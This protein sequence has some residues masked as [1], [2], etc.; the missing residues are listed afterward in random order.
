MRVLRA[1][2]TASMFLLVLVPPA[3][4]A[5]GPLE[6]T[7]P[8]PSVV[9]DP[10]ATAKFTITVATDT[11][12]RVDLTVVQ[13]PEG[14]DTSLRGGGSTVSA[15]TTAPDPETP[16]TISAELSA[17][18]AVPEDAAP[19]ANQVIIEGRSAAGTTIR[20]TLDISIEP[21]E[22][23]S[24]TM[25]SDFPSQSGSAD[26]TFN[27]PLELRNSTNQ[28]LTLSFEA[29]GPDGWRVDASPGGDANATTAVVDA[30]GLSSVE[31]SVDPP[32][33][34]AAGDYPI[35][36]R[37]LGGPEPVEIELGVTITGNYAMSMGTEDQRLS[38]NVTVGSSTTLNI[39]V[40]NDGSAPLENV[41]LSAT[42]PR[43]WTITFQTE[44]ITAI[45]PLDSVTVPVTIQPASNSVAG[46]Y[47]VTLRARSDQANDSIDV[48]TTVESSPIGGLL[49]IGV[50]V[51]VAG[52]L[53]FVFQRYGRR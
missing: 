17:E 48:R 30:G 42:P 41:A 37:A 45:P 24:I 31:V 11:P 33:D 18:V 39:V 19:G 13:Q 8:Y 29:A 27:F 10:G 3:V 22:P 21:V 50:L 44:T 51:L 35:V 25:T 47:V 26:D 28:Q 49:G 1:V 16:T 14:W 52:G 38:A 6:I 15:V 9:A 7:T 32:N 23:G 12:Q 20:L 2:L 43:N 34:E 46:D 4:L 40:A 36:V 53:F 5:Q